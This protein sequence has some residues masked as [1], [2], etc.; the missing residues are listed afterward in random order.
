LLLSLLSPPPRLAEERARR[1]GSAE[2][3]REI[4]LESRH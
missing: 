3:T 4:F 1:Q 2:V